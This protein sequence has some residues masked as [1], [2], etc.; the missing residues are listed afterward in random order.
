MSVLPNAPAPPQLLFKTHL[1]IASR[2]NHDISTTNKG[3]RLDE[4]R[5]DA[6]SSKSNRNLASIGRRRVSFD[7]GCHTVVLHCA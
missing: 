5:E 2:K 3:L 4:R 1:R 7:A 6:V